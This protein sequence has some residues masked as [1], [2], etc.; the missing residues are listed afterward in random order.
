MVDEY[1]AGLEASDREA[2]Q[3]GELWIATLWFTVGFLLGLLMMG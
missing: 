2:R 1:Q 3:V